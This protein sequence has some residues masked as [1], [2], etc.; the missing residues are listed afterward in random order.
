MCFGTII[1][2]FLKSHNLALDFN[3]QEDEALEISSEVSI[4]MVMHY[5]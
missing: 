4:S 1:C 5:C 2:L 3:I